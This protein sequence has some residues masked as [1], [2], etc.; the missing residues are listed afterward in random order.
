M[1]KPTDPQAIKVMRKQSYTLR[2]LKKGKRTR[3][4]LL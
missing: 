2:K 3:W 1:K 4:Q